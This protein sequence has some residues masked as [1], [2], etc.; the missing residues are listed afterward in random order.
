VRV[1]ET[2]LLL[3]TIWLVGVCVATRFPDDVLDVLFAVGAQIFS[4]A[5]PMETC[6]AAPKVAPQ[7]V[8]GW[9]NFSSAD[10]AGVHF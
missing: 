1:I 2:G 9:L 4:K 5:L 8:F 7:P 10:Y 3:S 6:E